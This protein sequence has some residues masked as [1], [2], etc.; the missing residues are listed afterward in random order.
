MKVLVTGATGFVGTALCA[1]LAASGVEVAPA[2]RNPSGLPHE[3]AVG[4]LTASTDWRPALA[5]CM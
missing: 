3:V 5:G 1:R 2:V 4:N